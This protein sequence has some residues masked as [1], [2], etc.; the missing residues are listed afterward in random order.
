MINKIVF[1]K[2]NIDGEVNFSLYCRINK[3]IGI[4]N[5]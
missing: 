1:Y 3:G 5:V 4:V 2:R